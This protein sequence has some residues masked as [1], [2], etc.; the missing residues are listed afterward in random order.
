MLGRIE[1]ERTAVPGTWL[2]SVDARTRQ[3]LLALGSFMLVFALWMAGQFLVLDYLAA[4]TVRTNVAGT[5]SALRPDRPLTIDIQGFQAAIHQARLYRRE[6][7]DGPPAGAEQS[8]GLRLQSDSPTRAHLV[9]ADGSSLLRPDG[10]YR[11]VVETSTL[12][13]GFPIPQRTSEVQQLEFQTVAGPHLVSAGQTLK[14]R[15]AQP[16]GVTWSL[17][18]Q[19]VE[20]KSPAGIAVRAWIDERDRT[21]TWVQVGGPNGEGLADGQTFEVQL[22]DAV[23]TDGL[24]LQRP[25]SVNIATPARPQLVDVPSA[26]VTLKYGDTLTLRSSVPLTDARVAVSNGSPA[27][28]AVDGTALRIALSDF[29]QGQTFGVQVID[30]TSVDGAPLA[31]PATVRV[32]TPA[33][34]AAPDVAPGDGV[35]AVDVK[36]HPS[37]T[38]AEPVAD[39][40]AVERA[41]SIEPRVTG[42]WHWTAPNKVEL[43]P[44]EKLPY[45]TD[46]TLA[47]K[48]G[49]NGPRAA[50][51]GY[52]DADVTSTFK[53]TDFKRIDVNLSRQQM[54]LFEDSVPVRTLW[55]ATGVSGAPTPTGT[56]SVQFKSPQMRFRGVNPDGS[57]YDIP[58]VHWVLPFWGD[59]TI[60]GAYWRGRFGTPGSAGCVSL[61]DADAKSVYDWANVGTPVTIHY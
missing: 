42:A 36:T 52:L 57:H 34:L 23:S 22:V 16:V 17:P 18:L 14:A 38:F 45:L 9:A 30:A 12:R 3:V 49:P 31:Q 20:A 24:Q 29:K 33:P 25:P 50:A 6:S 39:R 27:S 37:I 2:A 13:P 46:F 47:V 11:L 44:T 48:G 40:R 41:L 61:T 51:G 15:W 55:V 32:Q 21:R 58:D 5:G 54:T 56:F 26:P 28:V 53:T 19:S 35:G 1:D 60:H 10:S 43:V 59:Y 8:V 7:A 4:P